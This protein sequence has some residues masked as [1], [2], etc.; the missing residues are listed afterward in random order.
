[1]YVIVEHEGQ[2][3]RANLAK[4]IDISLTL[5]EGM[6][7]VNCFYAPYVEIVPVRM[8]T[9]VGS[10]EE[11]GIVNFKNVK[12]NPHGN[13][14]HTECVGHIAAG[15]YYIKDALKKAHLVARLISVFP[16]KGDNGDRIITKS[17][18]MDALNGDSVTEA[19]IIRTLPNDNLKRRTNYSGSNP[20][21]IAADAVDWLVEEGMNHLLIDLPSVDRE[22]DGGKLSAHHAFWKYPENTRTTATITELIFVD[23]LVKDGFY[24]LN[25]QTLNIELDVSPSKPLIFELNPI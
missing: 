12:L 23:E 18:I 16:E 6:E 11:G 10:V 25:L 19:M 13:G 2:Q 21:Y 9:F 20:P 7:T 1:M 5:K 15:D 22:E 3:F 8:G 14:T 17:R 4:A 24:L